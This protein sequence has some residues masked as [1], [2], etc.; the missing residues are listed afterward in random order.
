MRIIKKGTI[1]KKEWRGLCPT[2]HCEFIYESNDIKD[3]RH[4]GYYVVCPTC[5]LSINVMER[6]KIPRPFTSDNYSV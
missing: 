1:E 3:S 5:K 4:F 6:E 2:C